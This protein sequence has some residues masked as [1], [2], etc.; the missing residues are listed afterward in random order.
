M[1]AALRGA[2]PTLPEEERRIL[3]GMV[4][5]FLALEQMKS[6]HLYCSIIYTAASFGYAEVLIK[7]P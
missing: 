2:E 4:D 7:H 1:C 6:P 5:E 3:P